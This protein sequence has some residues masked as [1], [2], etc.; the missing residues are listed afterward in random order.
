MRYTA[1]IIHTT[2]L[3]VQPRSI[4]GADEELT[5]VRVGTGVGHAQNSVEVRKSVRQSRCIAI[6]SC[7]S[8]SKQYVPFTLMRERKVFII[9]LLSV[10][11]LSTRTIVVGK[12]TPLAHE[13]GNHCETRNARGENE[14]KFRGTPILITVHYHISHGLTQAGR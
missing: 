14:K 5:S 7:S 3:S 13:L 9:E 2:V 8:I 10:N 12:V 4:D 11:G 6:D 1:R